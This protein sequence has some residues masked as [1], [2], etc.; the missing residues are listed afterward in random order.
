MNKKRIIEIM[1]QEQLNEVYYNE[2]PVWIQE[3]YHNTARVGFVDTNEEKNVF[4]S[5]LYE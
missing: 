3:I 2:R 5:D 1:R 4:I